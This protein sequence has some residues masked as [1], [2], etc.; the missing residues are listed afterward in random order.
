MPPFLKSQKNCLEDAGSGKH[1][2][3][4]IYKRSGFTEQ[5]LGRFSPSHHPQLLAAATRIVSLWILLLISLNFSITEEKKHTKSHYVH[6]NVPN[7]ELQKH[8]LQ[9][10]C[11]DSFSGDTSNKTVNNKI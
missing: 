9:I 5:L 11:A 1:S 8:L 10:N 6:R 4:V 2:F 3:K 7:R